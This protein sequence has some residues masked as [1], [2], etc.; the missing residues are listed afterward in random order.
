[1]SLSEKYGAGV[2]ESDRQTDMQSVEAY[3]S[4][5]HPDIQSVA[6][7]ESEGLPSGERSFTDW[8]TRY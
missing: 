5:R 8:D 2:Y 1:M 3:E 7:Y 4:D 6:A